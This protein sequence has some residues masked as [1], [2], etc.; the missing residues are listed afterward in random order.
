M[1]NGYDVDWY[2]QSFPQVVRGGDM[3]LAEAK[4]EIIEHFTHE[5]EHAKS[6]IAHVRRLRA[7]DITETEREA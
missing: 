5:R 7:S 4:R 6:M 1:K 3:T 2:D